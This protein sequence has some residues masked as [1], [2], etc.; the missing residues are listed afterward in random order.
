MA[1]KTIRKFKKVFMKGQVIFR[2]GTDGDAMYIL[3]KGRVKIS[4]KIGD[5]KSMELQTF[6]PSE[7]FGEMALFGKLKRTATAVA[8]ED[9]SVIVITRETMNNQLDDLPPWF[10]TMFKALIERLRLTNL[11]LIPEK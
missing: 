6:G 4:I 3:E 2:Q 8:I 11:K 7:F 1:D 5:S 10:V 9:T